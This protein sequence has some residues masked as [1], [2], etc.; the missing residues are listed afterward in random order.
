METD[1]SAIA[2]FSCYF[3]KQKL[4][5]SKDII[6]YPWNLITANTYKKI[7]NGQKAQNKESSQNLWPKGYAKLYTA[8]CIAVLSLQR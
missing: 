5:V 4:A 8:V 1:N 3:M 7:Y 6:H 2:K